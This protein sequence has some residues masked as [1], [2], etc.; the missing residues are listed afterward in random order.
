MSTDLSFVV[1]LVDASSDHRTLH[2]TMTTSLPDRMMA[3]VH[4][5][6]FAF[7]DQCPGF[8]NTY[9]QLFPIPFRVLPYVTSPLLQTD[10]RAQEHALSTE[11]KS[12]R[13]YFSGR[14]GSIVPGVFADSIPPSAFREWPAS[15]LFGCLVSVLDMPNCF[16]SIEPG[17]PLLRFG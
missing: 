7:R 12:S 3:R 16:S 6:V 14:L 5:G 8:M 13:H 9:L 10:V 1:S 11:L 17:A 15:S 4:N 2:E